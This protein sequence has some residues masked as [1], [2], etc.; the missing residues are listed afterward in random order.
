MRCFERRSRSA[1]GPG[2]RLASASAFVA[3]RSG[4]STQEFLELFQAALLGHRQT[5]QACVQGSE[6]AQ[7]RRSA[8]SYQVRTHFD[9]LEADLH[10]TYT[11]EVCPNCAGAHLDLL[12]GEEKIAF[13]YELAE[14]PVMLHAHQGLAYW[15]ADCQKIHHAELPDEVLKGGLVGPRLTAMIGSL[16]GGCHTSY[17]TIQSF[18][19]DVMG[20]SLSTGML[21][22][23]V[24]KVSSALTVP[25]QE[26]F[27][28][29]PNQECLNIDETGHKENG[30]KMWNWVFRAPDFT[31]FTIEESR[32]AKVL[33]NV[34]GSEC[35]ALLG[36][37]Y[38][39]AYRA[40]MKDAPVIVQFCLAHLIR[41]ARFLSQSHDKVIKNYGQRV[42]DGLKK[43]FKI[44]HQRE[45]IPPDTFRR[46]L[47]KERDRFLEMAKRTKAGGD[48]RTLA[49]RF[50]KLWKGILHLYHK[51]PN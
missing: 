6:E 39:S 21:A 26:I 34:L 45:K 10:H 28:A 27:D 5:Q 13:Q 43:I 50:R 16:K 17:T 2:V 22:K 33:E 37:D 49:K 48:A 7:D 19:G 18:L 40:Y 14:K 25:Y 32:G 51:S 38:Y 1:E 24:G 30:Q 29:L 31:V 11:L 4:Q 36:S 15:C 42:L 35:E 46:R 41:E 23:V 3:G 20:A 44:I 12:D 47:Q 9:L 8:R